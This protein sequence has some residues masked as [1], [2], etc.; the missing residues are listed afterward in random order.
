MEYPHWLIVAGAV[1]VAIGFIGLA[2]RRNKDVEPNHEPTEMKANWKREGRDSDAA[3]P[4]PLAIA[5]ATSSALKSLGH[6]LHERAHRPF[7][8]FRDSEKSAHLLKMKS[9]LGAKEMSRLSF[10]LL[11]VTGLMLTAYFGAAAWRMSDESHMDV[12]GHITPRAK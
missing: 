11:I 7:R 10:A 6:H 2:F 4:S 3:P 1:L 12:T 9:K 5:T 8:P